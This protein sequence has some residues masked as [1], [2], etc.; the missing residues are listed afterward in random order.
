MS[1]DPL[2]RHC[3]PPRT[4]FRRQGAVWCCYC[5][6]LWTLGMAYDFFSASKAWVP[7][8]KVRELWGGQR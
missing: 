5:G 7:V 8:A 2:C 3:R 4:W 6:E 1:H